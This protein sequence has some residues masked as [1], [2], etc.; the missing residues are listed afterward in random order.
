MLSDRERMVLH[1]CCL[2]TI[3]KLTNIPNYKDLV[4]KMV[5]EIRQNRCRSLTDGQ[6]STLLRDISEEME[7]G[8]QMF[9]FLIDESM[10]HTDTSL[11]DLR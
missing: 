9:K 11:S 1:F 6:I 7:G 3:S 8:R 5:D 10:K 2:I 4:E